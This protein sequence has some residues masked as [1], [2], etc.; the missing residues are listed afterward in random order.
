MSNNFNL[1]PPLQMDGNLNEN[2]RRYHQKFVNY[3]HASDF[4]KATD[5][6]KVA[7]LLNVIGDEA[8]ETLIQ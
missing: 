4:V 3:L 7:I 5:E 1:P 2:W 8:V 6:R